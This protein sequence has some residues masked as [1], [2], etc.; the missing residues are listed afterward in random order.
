MWVNFAASVSSGHC[1]SR[2]L[3]RMEIERPLKLL[4]LWREDAWPS[5]TTFWP[6]QVTASR[7]CSPAALYHGNPSRPRLR[8]MYIPL[9]FAVPVNGPILPIGNDEGVPMTRTLERCVP[10]EQLSISRP[11]QG[12]SNQPPIPKKCFGCAVH[13]R[14]IY[15]S[16]EAAGMLR[17]RPSQDIRA[18]LGR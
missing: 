12:A 9:P 15:G 8:I 16:C 17:V 10:G 5:R 7:F 4:D 2:G 6:P 11:G 1:R 18:M 13:P 14:D 3:Y